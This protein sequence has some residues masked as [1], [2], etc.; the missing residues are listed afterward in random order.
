MVDAR[1]IVRKKTERYKCSILKAN[2]L[3]NKTFASEIR[4][5]F[6]RRERNPFATNMTTSPSRQS[7]FE[8]QLRS[9]S[10][11]SKRNRAKRLG[12]GQFSE[13]PLTEGRIGRLSR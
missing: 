13:N 1:T 10:S 12:R 3:L 11:S 7:G 8:S 5:G 2:K 9:K 6:Q 4:G